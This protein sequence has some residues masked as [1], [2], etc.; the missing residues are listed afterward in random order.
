M[1][2]YSIAVAV[3]FH[4]FVH[5][6]SFMYSVPV[7]TARVARLHRAAT[8]KDFIVIVYLLYLLQEVEE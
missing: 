8:K 2:F 3:P 5:S 7:C 1:K 6:Y 4:S